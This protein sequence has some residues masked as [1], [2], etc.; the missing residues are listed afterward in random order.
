MVFVHFFFCFL[1]INVCCLFWGGGSIVVGGFCCCS[2]EYI[3]VA[4]FVEISF[5]VGLCFLFFIFL[6][7]PL[8]V[9]CFSLCMVF[10]GCLFFFF[11][12]LELGG[13]DYWLC[14]GLFVRFWVRCGCFSK[15]VISFWFD[16]L[17]SFRCVFNSLFGS[18]AILGVAYT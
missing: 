16:V 12:A 3:L 8:L 1:S 13:S 4:F 6:S 7:F 17:V 5:L 9:V 2:S 15:G 14:S 18:W 11:L 10:F